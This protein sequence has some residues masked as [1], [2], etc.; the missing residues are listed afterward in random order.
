MKDEQGTVIYVGK[1]MALRNR[2]RS[3]FQSTR[4]S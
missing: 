2:V 3:Y 4:D 1:A